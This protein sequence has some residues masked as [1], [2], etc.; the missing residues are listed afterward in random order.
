[1]E[2]YLAV[3]LEIVL[4][5]AVVALGLIAV[6]KAIMTGFAISW[7]PSHHLAGQTGTSPVPLEAQIPLTEFMDRPKGRRR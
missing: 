1:M 4:I 3:Q 2:N 6:G 5:A 7:R